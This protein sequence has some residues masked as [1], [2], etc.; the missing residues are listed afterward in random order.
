[1]YRK[2]AL[3]HLVLIFF[4][5]CCSSSKPYQLTDGE[6]TIADSLD[7]DYEIIRQM[8]K[9][10][11]N[12]IEPF[13]YSISKSFEN[14]KEVE[15]NP[16]RLNGLVVKE[17]HSDSYN[18]IFELKKT[19]AENGYTIFMLE[20]NFDIK[21]RPDVLAILKTTDKYEI[22]RSVQTD[23]INYGIDNDSLISIIKR[24]DEDYSLELIGASG[25]WCE[26]IIHKKSS[27][28]A[29]LATEIYSVCP[30]VVEQGTGSVLELERILTESRRLYL[31]WD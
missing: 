24:F 13:H 10:N 3:I 21:S 31:W 5:I 30:D 20:N 26:F 16:I 18:L 17:K 6:K 19:F 15:L 23:G 29:K 7:I 9:Y 27:D 8:R 14:G 4:F 11:R 12:E 28:W 1:M 22:L 25:D 2:N